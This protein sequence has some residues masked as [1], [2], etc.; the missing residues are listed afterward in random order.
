MR[1]MLYYFY[2]PLHPLATPSFSIAIDPQGYSVIAYDCAV[3]EYEPINLYITYSKARVGNA[4]AGWIT[5]GNRW[6]SSSL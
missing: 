6:S 5:T 2:Y 3:D 1:Q 4:D